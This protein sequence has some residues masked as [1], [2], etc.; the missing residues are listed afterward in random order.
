M[1]YCKTFYCKGP[2]LCTIRVFR[3]FSLVAL[4]SPIC[5]PPPARGQTLQ[6]RACRALGTRGAIAR[7]SVP[8]QHLP[9]ENV[10]KQCCTLC[11][12]ISSTQKHLAYLAEWWT[13]GPSSDPSGGG[14]ALVGRRHAQTGRTVPPA[15]PLRHVHSGSSDTAPTMTRNDKKKY[16]C[17][18][19][20]TFCVFRLHVSSCA[21]VV[22]A[23]NRRYL[24]WVSRMIVAEPRDS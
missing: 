8:F 20:V 4:S 6:P 18:D 11:S 19:E 16:C 1:T 2:K 9:E 24:G 5:L 14:T 7:P 12:L 23:G 10:L 15:G 22:V 13:P 21:F 3:L 17:V